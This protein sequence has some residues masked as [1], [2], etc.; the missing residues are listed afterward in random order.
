MLRG[1]WTALVLVLAVQLCVGGG[2]P[3]DPR[4][5]AVHYYVGHEAASAARGGSNETQHPRGSMDY[6]APRTWHSQAGQ[7]HAVFTLLGRKRGGYFVD[8]AANHPTYISNTRALERDYGWSG[9]CVDG[10]E[11]LVAALARR[12]RCTVVS[13]IVSHAS[14]ATVSYRNVLSASWETGLSGVV[15]SGDK[16]AGGSSRGGWLARL[17]AWLGLQRISNGPPTETVTRTTVALT[18]IFA[19][20]GTPRTFDYFSLD[21]EGHEWEVLRAFPFDTYAFRVLTIERPADATRALLHAHNYSY[22]RHLDWNDGDDIDEMWVHHSLRARVKH[23][24]SAKLCGCCCRRGPSCQPELAKCS[25][26]RPAK[27]P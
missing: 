8:L 20:H 24:L 1:T 18:E 11:R 25:K 22:A 10:N 16:A 9:M 21:V 23:V 17:G 2:A 5:R 15:H 3:E 6:D 13:A 27:K 12:R 19:R 14:D 7:D 26:R 4:W